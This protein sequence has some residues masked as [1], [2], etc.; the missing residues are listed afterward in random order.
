MEAHQVDDILNTSH[1]VNTTAAFATDIE[2]NMHSPA[3]ILA[4][5][6]YIAPYFNKD[7]VSF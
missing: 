1:L 6:N 7:D 2:I 3:I 4:D 5:D